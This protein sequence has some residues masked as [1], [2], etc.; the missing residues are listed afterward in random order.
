[1]KDSLGTQLG[2]AMREARLR[3][4]LSQTDVAAALDVKASTV[5]RWESGTTD[6]PVGKLAS[7]A[8]VVNCGVTI[9]LLRGAAGQ[10]GA[11]LPPDGELQL[12]TTAVADM[13]DE[14]DHDARM[15]LRR[16]A[17]YLL[18]ES[19]SRQAKPQVG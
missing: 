18:M 17:E 2:S 16:F 4:G 10:S 5:S 13:I 9:S 1:M 15:Q 8:K 14:M 7:F 6:V 3:A 12:L 11:F 19:R